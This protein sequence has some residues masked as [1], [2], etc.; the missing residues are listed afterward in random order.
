MI[1]DAS[2]DGTAAVVETTAAG[3]QVAQGLL[4]ASGT[5]PGSGALFGLAPTPQGLYYVDDA[6]NTLRLLTST[7]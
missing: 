7:P 2:G 4:D 5:P 3:G 1:D 6:T